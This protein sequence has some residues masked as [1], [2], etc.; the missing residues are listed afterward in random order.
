MK[1]LGVPSKQIDS[2]VPILLMAGTEDPLGGEK[3]NK[4]LLD[5]YRRA[6][7]I[8]VELIAYH[9]ARHEVFNETNKNQVLA[10]LVKWLDDR[11]DAHQH[12]D[13]I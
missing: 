12:L 6:G 3:G 7:A 8:D 13:E 4:K 2:H 1:L 11:L 9:G 10:D 5:A